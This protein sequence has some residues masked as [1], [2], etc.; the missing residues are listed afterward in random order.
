MS[1]DEAIAAKIKI[2]SLIFSTGAWVDVT[3]EYH[4]KLSLIEIRAQIKVKQ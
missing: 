2:L 3:E 1:P 4:N